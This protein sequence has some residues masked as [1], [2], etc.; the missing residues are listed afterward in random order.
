MAEALTI[1]ADKAGPVELELRDAI[2]K[3]SDC[4][5]EDMIIRCC[6]TA[7]KQGKTPADELK[8]VYVRG[9]GNIIDLLKAYDDCKEQYIRQNHDKKIKI[10]LQSGKEIELDPIKDFGRVRQLPVLKQLISKMERLV[11]GDDAI[12]TTF[13]KYAISDEDRKYIR[14]LCWNDR[15]MVWGTRKFEPSQ[16]FAV[17]LWQNVETINSGDAYGEPDEQCPYCTH[18]RSHWNSHSKGAEYEQYWYLLIPKGAVC[19]EGDLTNPDVVKVFNAM[20]G[21]GPEL[22]V[23]QNDSANDWC[24]RDDNPIS[25]NGDDIHDADPDDYVFGPDGANYLDDVVKLHDDYFYDYSNGEAAK[26]PDRYPWETQHQYRQR[27][28]AADEENANRITFINDFRSDADAAKASAA[29]FDVDTDVWR[30][31]LILDE[32][33][34][35]EGALKI[36]VPKKVADIVY[37]KNTEISSAEGLPQE[38]QGQSRIEFSGCRIKSLRGWNMRQSAKNVG[39][40]GCE[41][42]PGGLSDAFAGADIKELEIYNS[43]T[44]GTTGLQF[45]RGLGKI[46]RIESLTISSKEVRSF[47]GL[48]DAAESVGNIFFGSIDQAEEHCV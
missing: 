27:R 42:D 13:A 37:I 18:S 8:R 24:D 29:E 22:L 40:Y 38:F 12:P 2:K 47:D 4:K 44:A 16:K 31:Q 9:L 7:E 6:R 26:I 36:R 45:M 17:Q 20:R 41:I 33:H 34:F 5:Y 10:E 11:A 25:E 39:F 43:R 23:C 28:K 46:K 35:E 14:L 15:V 32:S 21:L 3:R 30:P 19:A 48:R 1:P